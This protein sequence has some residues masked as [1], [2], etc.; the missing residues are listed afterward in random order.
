MTESR[1][2]LKPT[3]PEARCQRKNPWTQ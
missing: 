1:N 3:G 2:V